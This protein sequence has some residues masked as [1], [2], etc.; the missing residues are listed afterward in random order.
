MTA[1]TSRIKISTI[2]V[3]KIWVKNFCVPIFSAG[4]V[5]LFANVWR[6]PCFI[7]VWPYLQQ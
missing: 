5:E 4:L 7:E 2:S 6:K 1:Q 3:A